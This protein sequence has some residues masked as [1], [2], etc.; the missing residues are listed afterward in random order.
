MNRVERF[1]CWKCRTSR[2]DHGVDTKKWFLQ[3][4]YPPDS[5]HS[6]EPPRHATMKRAE[7][8][9]TLDVR[10]ELLVHATNMFRSS[11]CEERAKLNTARQA[12][13]N[14]G[15]IVIEVFVAFDPLKKPLSVY[16]RFWSVGASLSDTTERTGWVIA[17]R[18][19]RRESLPDACELGCLINS[20]KEFSRDWLASS[21]HN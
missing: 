1:A 10:C 17:C 16:S 12:C 21:D 13:T 8:L 15:V 3:P 18:D 9:A 5:D 4:A 2:V 7:Y 19:K 6:D 11:L 14:S 20:R